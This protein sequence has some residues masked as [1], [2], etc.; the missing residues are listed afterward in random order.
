MDKTDYIMIAL[1]V[2][3]L[4][5]VAVKNR[6]NERKNNIKRLAESF[7]RPFCNEE[8]HT[9][10][11]HVEV[12]NRDL[13][14]DYDIN[15]EIW[16]DLDMS[17]VYNM[18]D[19]SVSAIGEEYLYSSLRTLSD[20]E[21]LDKRCRLADEFEKTGVSQ[22]RVI[23]SNIRKQYHFTVRGFINKLSNLKK[24]F[25]AVHVLLCLMFFGSI[26]YT[27]FNPFVGITLVIATGLINCITYVFSKSKSQNYNYSISV[28]V[29]WLTAVNNLPK[30]KDGELINERVERMHKLAASFN[31]I[32]RV[33]WLFA[34]QNAVASFINVILD[35]VKFLTHI[36]IIEFYFLVK[37]LNKNID[38]LFEL[39]KE[40]GE[41]ELGIIINGIRKYETV[42]CIPEFVT[43]TRPSLS[44]TGMVHP[45]IEDAVPNDLEITNNALI[46]GSNASG[47]SSFLKMV[48]INCLLAET[49]KLAFSES[50]KG[51]YMGICTSFD[52]S[53]SIAKGDSFYIAEIKR[54]K[55]MLSKADAGECMLIGI[56]EILKGTNT[57]ERIAASAAILKHFAGTKSMVI[58]ATHDVELTEILDKEYDNF[59][60]TEN[61]NDTESLFDYKLRRGRNYNGNAIKLLEIFEYPHDIVKMSREIVLEEKG[62]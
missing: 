53:D 40:T 18:I 55:E 6:I 49:L 59:Y 19:Q 28:I 2:A 31:K 14:A 4:L 30:T 57:M 21:T 32:K 45:L 20:K 51:S 36:D 8:W 27:F 39:Y 22:Y 9:N 52:I 5:F 56:D 44:A 7:G 16:H 42:N 33:S 43:G 13:A 1:F 38:G 23:L 11:N 25:I 3:L 46:T 26:V 58:A 60:F 29:K 35:Y 41:F 62:K 50:Y 24:E 17:Q 54:I 15:D 61:P 12:I 34:P 37:F 48:T 47:K 10:V